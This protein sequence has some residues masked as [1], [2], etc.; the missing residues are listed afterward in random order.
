MN[1][2]PPQIAEEIYRQISDIHKEPMPKP[3]TDQEFDSEW[4]EKID[5]QWANRCER[6]A[7]LWHQLRQVAVRDLNCPMWAVSA[8]AETAAMYRAKAQLNIRARDA[9]KEREQG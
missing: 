7:K 1:R 8:A 3:S 6:L 9:M 2:T 4:A 5:V